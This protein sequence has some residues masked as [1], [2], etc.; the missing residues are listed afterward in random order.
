MPIKQ[1][2]AIIGKIFLHYTDIVNHLVL[3]DII[4]ISAFPIVTMILALATI[5]LVKKTSFG[6]PHSFIY[7]LFG[8]TI[9]TYIILLT[10][11]FQA[12]RYFLPVVSLWGV[13]LPFFLIDLI[14][15]VNFSFVKQ[16]VKA[17]R[18]AQL[19]FETVLIILI[20]WM[21]ISFTLWYIFR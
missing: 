9:V 20:L 8:I 17:Q 1:V 2:E 12:D 3:I 19:V 4:G 5:F 14:S 16:T 11:Q 15:Q 10:S 18:F 13:F 6:L 7:S 21:P